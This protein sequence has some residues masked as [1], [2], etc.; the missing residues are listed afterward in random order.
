MPGDLFARMPAIDALSV[1]IV[2]LGINVA[3]TAISNRWFAVAATCIA[4]VVYAVLAVVR[5]TIGEDDW[6][7]GPRGTGWGDSASDRENYT[8]FVLRDGT[9]LEGLYAANVSAASPLTSVALAAL[10]ELAGRVSTGGA[11]AR[12][13]YREAITSFAESVDARAVGLAASDEYLASMGVIRG[14]LVREGHTV[15]VGLTLVFTV[16]AVS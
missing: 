16:L 1:L 13:E 3:R 4:V 10:G 2:L 5:L 11:V 6:L 9:A 14:G 15:L 12:S 8:A 7:T